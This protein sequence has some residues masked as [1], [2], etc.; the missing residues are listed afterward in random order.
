MIAGAAHSGITIE[1]LDELGPALEKVI[2]GGTRTS[3]EAWASTAAQARARTE[4]SVMS[5]EVFTA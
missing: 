2:L 1:S 5:R 4:S 3:S